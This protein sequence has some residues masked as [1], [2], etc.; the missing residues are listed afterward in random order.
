[1]TS[2]QNGSSVRGSLVRSADRGSPSQHGVHAVPCQGARLFVVG[3]VEYGDPRV[4][5]AV[6]EAPDG[7]GRQPA[8]KGG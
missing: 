4:A 7:F 2:P 8:R 5:P 6:P 1:M 3:D